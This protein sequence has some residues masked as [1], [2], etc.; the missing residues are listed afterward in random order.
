M[1]ISI[2]Q[3]GYL[4]WLGFFE[5]IARV[6][7]MVIYDSVR[8]DKQSWRNRNRIR[9]AEGED[10]WKWLTVPVGSKAEKELIK[11]VKIR[12]DGKW[13]KKHWNSIWNSYH[14]L[15]Y[16]DRYSDFFNELYKK[17]WEYLADLDV[18]IIEYLKNELGLTQRL[19]RSSQL[20]LRVKE[21]KN[22]K[23]I[24]VC[25]IMGS[26]YLYDSAGSK[27]FIDVALFKARGIEVE[28]QDYKHP[29]Y[30]QNSFATFIPY[31]SVIDLMFNYGPNSLEVIMSEGKDWRCKR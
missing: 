18:H 24:E 7:V 26:D 31:L 23:L 6:D 29:L 2:M 22:E 21:G 1:K 16:F 8:Y 30:N 4:P 5:L 3:P 15:P 20:P 25:E 14:N 10:G 17:E 27:K 12:E 28:F 13:R 11:D 9:I 19:V